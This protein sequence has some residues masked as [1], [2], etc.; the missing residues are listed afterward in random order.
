MANPLAAPA[1]ESLATRLTLATTGLLVALRDG[2]GEH[3]WLD[4]LEYVVVEVGRYLRGM[5]ALGTIPL[6]VAATDDTG[7]TGDGGKAA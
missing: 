2:R 3:R 7:L 5:Q 4:E 6:A 1:V